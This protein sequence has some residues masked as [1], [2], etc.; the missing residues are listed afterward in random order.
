MIWSLSRHIYCN[1]GIYIYVDSYT[2]SFFNSHKKRKD[3]LET[4]SVFLI[5]CLN[6]KYLGWPYKTYIK[7][8]KK[9][10][11]FEELLNE[12]NIETVIATFCCYD[13]GAK[14][15]EVVQKIATDQKNYRKCFLRVIVWWI[16]KIYQS[17]IV[18]KVWLLTY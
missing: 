18:K 17:I 11:I 13:Y 15:F 7:K 8:A 10:S 3:T 1:G 2:H 6:L 4:R 9:G 16:A 12:N 14:G 5:F